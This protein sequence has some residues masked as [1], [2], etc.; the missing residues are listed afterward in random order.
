[1]NISKIYLNLHTNNFSTHYIRNVYSANCPETFMY[2]SKRNKHLYPKTICDYKLLCSIVYIPNYILLNNATIYHRKTTTFAICPYSTFECHYELSTNNKCL[3]PNIGEIYFVYNYVNCHIKITTSYFTM[4]TLNNFYLNDFHNNANILRH[5]K[6]KGTDPQNMQSNFI[7]KYLKPAILQTNYHNILNQ[8]MN[9]IKITKLLSILCNA[10]V[11]PTIKNINNHN[12]HLKCTFR[13]SNNCPYTKD[14]FNINL[15]QCI[16]AW[17]NEYNLMVLI[18]CVNKSKT[19]N[20]YVC[21]QQ[22]F[23]DGKHYINYS[24][25]LNIDMPNLIPPH[26]IALVCHCKPH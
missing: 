1:M 13:E 15:P 19:E 10:H 7:I 3:Y 14:S 21:P 25:D 4:M 9:M 24:L 18:R 2:S 12:L 22:N 17:H 20:I 6:C 26:Q 16:Y 11:K 23:A 8:S 5:S